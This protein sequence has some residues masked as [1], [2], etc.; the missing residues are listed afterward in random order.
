MNTLINCYINDSPSSMNINTIFFADDNTFSM[1]IDRN[2][3][4]ETVENIIETASDWFRANELSLNK[5]KTASM[6]FTTQKCDSQS[7]KFLGIHLEYALSWRTH[8]ER[9]AIRLSRQ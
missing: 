1:R 5:I 7:I 2:E 3:A 9:L 6:I 4:D 8:T